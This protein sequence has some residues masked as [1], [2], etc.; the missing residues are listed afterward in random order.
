V[1]VVSNDDDDVFE[2]YECAGN[3]FIAK[4][5]QIIHLD[6]TAYYCTKLFKDEKIKLL[7]SGSGRD[8]M[9]NEKEPCKYLVS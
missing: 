8:I 5:P 9:V 2:F 7:Q 4:T 1:K 3:K 6:P